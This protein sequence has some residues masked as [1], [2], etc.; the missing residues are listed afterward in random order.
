MAQTSQAVAPAQSAVAEAIVAL[1]SP[2]LLET[3]EQLGRDVQVAEDGKAQA[4]RKLGQCDVALFDILN[5]ENYVFFKAVSAA[6]INGMR[7]K[8]CPTDDAAER[9]FQRA[10]KRIETSCSYVKPKAETKAAKAMSEKRA[11]L[12]AELDGKTPVALEL[13]LTAALEDGSASALKR[14]T[15]LRSELDKRNK[16][17]LEAEDIARK[18][19]LDK[20]VTR[21]KELAKAKTADA[22][23]K[24][25]A[26]LLA[27]S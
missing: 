7:D 20:L 16:P 18:A 9:A 12:Q 4:E 1:L 15:V 13:E 22:D 24:L 3:V 2:E 6:F 14:A 25:E 21:A 10:V 11:K 23:A 26:A 5:G 17:L 8:G 19:V 27:L